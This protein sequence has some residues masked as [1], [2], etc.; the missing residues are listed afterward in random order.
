[1]RK[2]CSKCGKQVSEFFEIQI[3]KVFLSKEV[4]T[5]Y[6]YYGYESY[7][8]GKDGARDEEILY[9]RYCFKCAPKEFLGKID[10]ESI[11]PSKRKNR[12]GRID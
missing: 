11:N 9:R 3:K 7:E 1:M 5:K 2:K 12:K 10:L 8:N 4:I 6:G